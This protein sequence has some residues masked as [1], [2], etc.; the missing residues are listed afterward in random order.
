MKTNIITLIAVA[1]LGLTTTS[2]TFAKTADSN[3]VTVLNNATKINSI[4]ANGNVEVYIVS[5]AKDGV[6]VFD[7]Y[8]NQNALVQNENGVL[9]V[10]SYKKEKLVIEVT[11]TDLRSITA[12]GNAVVKADGR[13]STIEL[14]VDL[15]DNA[16]AQLKV[17]AL[18]AKFNVNDRAKA[19][20]SGTIEDYE[21]NYSRS[22]SVNRT[23][24]AATN[25]AEKITT[26]LSQP[27]KPA[28]AD[29]TNIASL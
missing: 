23:D 19:D 9:R 15:S 8:Y 12:T 29:V 5:G 1:T 20:I 10:T 11:V 26:P 4:E 7:S 28:I 2:K 27:A 25:R 13:L 18:S 22:S 16:L 3:Y 21:L 24:L 14:N 6:K 17:D